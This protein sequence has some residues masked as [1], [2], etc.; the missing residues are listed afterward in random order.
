MIATARTQQAIRCNFG[1]SA[2]QRDKETFADCAAFAA[3]VA[4][5]GKLAVTFDVP[6]GGSIELL[7]GGAQEAHPRSRLT[8]GAI[9][10]FF[11]N[12]PEDQHVER[13]LVRLLRRLADALVD[14]L[15]DGAC[16]ELGLRVPRS[17]EP[18]DACGAR[19][20]DK[21]WPAFMQAVLVAAARAG[22]KCEVIRTVEMDRFIRRRFSDRAD[23]RGLRV[24]NPAS[25][26]L[27]ADG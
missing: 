3:H 9:P 21:V 24:A 27:W 19:R 7:S 22:R 20:A 13:E 18:F 15:P 25:A 6:A 11:H 14:E 23:S 10:R 1:H 4:Y 16:I 8:N 5:G 17:C 2:R 12:G 26:D